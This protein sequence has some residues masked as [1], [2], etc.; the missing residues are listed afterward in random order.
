MTKL[1]SRLILLSI[2]VASLSAPARAAGSLL[3][4]DASEECF[5]AYDCMNLCYT[6]C[7][8]LY[9]VDVEA[10]CCCDFTPEDRCCA[11]DCKP[12]EVQ[13]EPTDYCSLPQCDLP[14]ARQKF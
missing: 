1:F 14:A 12:N 5:D 11:C 3:S 10:F 4:C 13:P 2:L 6:F 8:E 7:H 9:N